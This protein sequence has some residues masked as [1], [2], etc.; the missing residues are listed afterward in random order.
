VSVVEFRESGRSDGGCVLHVGGEFDLAVVDEFLEWALPRVEDLEV[1]EIDLG[2]VSFIDSS[3]LGALVRV[4]NEAVA[5][6]KT[7]SLV[8]PGH[9]TLRLLELTGLQHAFDIRSDQA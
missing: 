6:G 1:I 4:R 8:N 9:A 7:L 2:A 5:K 3:G